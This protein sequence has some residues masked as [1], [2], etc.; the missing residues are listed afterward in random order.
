MTQ[1]TFKGTPIEISGDFPK[2]GQTVNNFTLT[3]NNLQETNLED[4]KNHI[5]ILN[6][7][8]SLDTP[9]C[10]QS[11]KKFNAAAVKLLN[12]KVLCISNDLPFAQARFCGV[13]NIKNAQTFSAFRHVEFSRQF[14][15][16][17]T[18]GLLKGLLARSIIVLDA[19]RKVAYTELVSEITNEP[20]YEKCLTVVNSL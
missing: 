8:P 7:F 12:A 6:I 13:E 2:L 19:A 14:G 4:F 15:V 3:D 10:S 11:V 5:L 18:D 9:V 20:D 16:D 17:I 1:V